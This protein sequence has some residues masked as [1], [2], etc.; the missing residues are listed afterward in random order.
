MFLF[1][2]GCV[3]QIERSLE[4][5]PVS[6][7]EVK[8]PQEL[9]VCPKRQER[10]DQNCWQFDSCRGFCEDF[11]LSRNLGSSAEER[12]VETCYSWPED[13]VKDFQNLVNLID[14]RDIF[15]INPEVLGCFLRINELK[16]ILFK[17]L[18]IR[19]SKMF[20]EVVAE[21]SDLANQIRKEDDTEFSILKT[22]FRNIGGQILDAIKEP[23]KSGN[24]FL[25][26]LSYAENQ[27]AWTWINDYFSYL[28]GRSSGCTDPFEYYCEVLEDTSSQSLK[29]LFADSGFEREYRRSIQ[30]QTCGGDSCEYGNLG[31]F[32]EACENF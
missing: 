24:S 1:L 18:G 14:R 2:F 28:C 3:R 17:N 13:L 16:G 11:Y 27:Q 22:L 5:E 10:E 19:R 23:L 26:L 31:D 7:E 29:R 32:K 12:V 25:I 20:L 6:E 9:F 4:P 8:S 21:D 30:S 15:K